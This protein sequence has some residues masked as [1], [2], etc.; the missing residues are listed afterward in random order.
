[1][2]DVRKFEVLDGGGGVNGHTLA[3]YETIMDA[4]YDKAG[5]IPLAAAIGVLEIAKADLIDDQRE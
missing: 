2:S 1:M 4:I 3:L 5:M